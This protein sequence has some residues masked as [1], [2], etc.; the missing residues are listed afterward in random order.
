VLSRTDGTLYLEPADCRT[1]A[2][3]IVNR[4]ESHRRGRPFSLCSC[5]TGARLRSRICASPSVSCSW[6][7]IPPGHQPKGY[8]GDSGHSGSAPG[9][10]M[11][12]AREV[13]SSKS[14]HLIG[15]L[16][17]F[18]AAFFLPRAVGMGRHHTRKYHLRTVQEHRRSRACSASPLANSGSTLHRADT[19]TAETASSNN[20]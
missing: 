4:L 12:E 5:I 14:E 16:G 3:R 2:V 19:N 8:G 7:V 18:R 17:S 15:P 10:K 6:R 11:N 13:K 1:I 9:D 20:R